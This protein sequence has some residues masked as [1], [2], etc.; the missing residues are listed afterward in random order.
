MDNGEQPAKATAEGPAGTNSC[1]QQAAPQHSS[2]VP[3]GSKQGDGPG[4]KRK[5]TAGAAAQV[6]RRNG[7]SRQNNIAG[8]KRRRSADAAAVAKGAEQARSLAGLPSEQKSPHGMWLTLPQPPAEATEGAAPTSLS[9]APTVGQSRHVAGIGA[10]VRRVAAAGHAPHGMCLRLSNLPAK[11]MCA[12]QN[13]SSVIDERLSSNT[14]SAAV[15]G[16]AATPGFAPGKTRPRL[17]EAPAGLTGAAGRIAPHGVA[18]RL[19]AGIYTAVGSE[20]VRNAPRG[21]QPAGRPGPQP[22]GC[23]HHSTPSQM[24]TA[25]MMPP[26]QSLE[27]QLRADVSLHSGGAQC[28]VQRPNMSGGVSIGGAS[29]AAVRRL[30]LKCRFCAVHGVCTAVTSPHQEACQYFNHCRCI[31]CRKLRLQHRCSQEGYQRRAV[32]ARKAAA[33][34]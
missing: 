16:A 5:Q 3:P 6:S 8:C 18:N 14:S 13:A 4:G 34:V 21:A 2:D 31:H 28:A 12:A 19:V 1:G 15:R 20:A 29:S 30:T 26:R 9:A 27:P 11:T 33:G 32:A 25:A 24:A 17:S 10:A 23:H 7:D 22:A